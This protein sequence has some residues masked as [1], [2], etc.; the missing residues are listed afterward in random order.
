[1]L[2]VDSCAGVQCTRWCICDT[3]RAAQLDVLLIGNYHRPPRER[4]DRAFPRTSRGMARRARND[5]ASGDRPRPALAPTELPRPGV[6][7]GILVA[8]LCSPFS[9][10]AGLLNRTLTA[11]PARQDQGI[12]THPATPWSAVP[13]RGRR[14]R[15]AVAGGVAH[16]TGGWRGLVG[17]PGRGGGYPARCLLVL[18]AI[19]APALRPTSGTAPVPRRPAGGTWAGCP[20]RCWTAGGSASGD[21]PGEGHGRGQCSA[22]EHRHGAGRVLGAG[23][24]LRRRFRLPRAVTAPIEMALQRGM[25]TRRGA[26]RTLRLAWTV[27]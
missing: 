8:N 2:Q 10:D 12:L 24:V 4:Y 18:V 11:L 22:G 23:P 19:R 7:L 20:D 27:G 16:T 21:A 1:M 15:A 6:G 5:R 3:T 26:D 25:V 14:V 13:R 17:S 9:S